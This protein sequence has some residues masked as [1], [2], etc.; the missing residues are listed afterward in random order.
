MQI[1]RK[2]AEG[3]RWS[4]PDGRCSAHKRSL[5]TPQAIQ[6]VGHAAN[7]GTGLMVPVVQ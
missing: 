7:T 5:G 2:R 3:V 1:E 4:R 6:G